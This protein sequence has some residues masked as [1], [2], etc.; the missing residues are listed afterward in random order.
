MPPVPTCTPPPASRILPCPHH[1]SHLVVSAATIDWTFNDRFYNYFREG[2]SNTVKKQR[3]IYSMLYDGYNDLFQLIGEDAAFLKHKLSVLRSS[4]NPIIGMHIRRGDRHPLELEFSKDYLPFERFTGT[5]QE[6]LRRVQSALPH[7]ST[8]IAPTL[9]LASDD[10]DIVIS[11][12]I[13]QT[14]PSDFPSLSRAQDRIVL[15][16]KRTLEP[17][18]PFREPGSA[19][20]KH[21]D[22]NSGWEG[23][24]YAALFNSLGR[25]RG[26]SDQDVS[27]EVQAQ[28]A[29]LRALLG[30]AYLLDLAVLSQTDGVVCAVSSAACRLMGVMMGWESVVGKR[31]V[32]VDDG[33]GWSWDGR[34]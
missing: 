31:W 5:A 26:D 32:N 11:P 8:A 15:A 1:A 13:L 2:R 30:R 7:N 27:V 17:A 20:T 4:N 22:E 10:P 16:S 12:D 3:Q 18:V 28:A 9:L 29:Q 6:V 21:V 25:Q 19:Y 14:L 33:R 23:G 34:K 24:F